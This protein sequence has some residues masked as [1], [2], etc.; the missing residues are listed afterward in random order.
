[1]LLECGG[2]FLP[3]NIKD[4]V[5]DAKIRQLADLTGESITEVVRIAVEQRLR[6]ESTRQ[7]A[8]IADQLL[9]IGARLSANPRQFSG[10]ADAALGYGAGGLP[11]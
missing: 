2:S 11:S 10:D 7:R 3:I 1:M 4:P 5:T 8:G 6:R 9:A